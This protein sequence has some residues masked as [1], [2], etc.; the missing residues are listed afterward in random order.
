MR[1]FLRVG[2][3]FG[4]GFRLARRD[5]VLGWPVVAESSDWIVLQQT[6]W[7]FG[8]ALVMR[9]TDGQLTWATRVKYSS[10]VARATWLVVGVLHRRFAPRALHR[11]VTRAA[12]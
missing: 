2:W 12:P 10:P 7:L 3:R 9:V 8:V 5:A 6:S 4:L 11:A 1:I